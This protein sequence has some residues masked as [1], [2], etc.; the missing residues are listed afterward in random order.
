MKKKLF[1]KFFVFAVIAALVTVTSC[2]DYDD[3]ISRIDADLSALKGTALAQADLT[4]LKT[5]LETSITAVQT[6]LNAAK[7]KLTALEGS[8]AT[9]EDIDAAKADVL[10]KAVKLETFTTFK[11]DVED[12]LATLKADLAKAATKEEV[13]ALE[14]L[15]DA[16]IS[17][18]KL[19][20]AGAIAN[21]EALKEVV[22]GNS[23]AIADIYTKLADQLEAIEANEDEIAA[24]KADLQTKYDELSG[25][26]ATLK[27]NLANLTTALG[28]LDDKVDGIK[29]EL[30]GKINGL[31]SQ[32]SALNGL[33]V[34]VF[35]NLD[36]RVTSL[37]FIPDYSSPD[38][39]PQLPVHFLGEWYKP[40]ATVENWDPNH[41]YD[42]LLTPYKGITY[43][44]F[45]VSPSNATLEDF[46]VVGLLQQTSEVLFR[47]AEEPLLK[48]VVEDVTLKNGILTVPILVHADLYDRDDFTWGSGNGPMPVSTRA[49]PDDDEELLFIPSLYWYGENI[50]VV[51]QVKNKNMDA[52]DNTERLVVSSEYVRTQLSLLFS[53]I[54]LIDEDGDV[55]RWRNILPSHKADDI[56]LDSYYKP[57]TIIELWN[58]YNRNDRTY[59]RDYSINLNDYVQAIAEFNDTWRVLE[60]FGYDNIE[61]HFVF[62][63]IDVQNEGV[64]QSSYVNLNGATGVISVKPGT[65][66]NANQAA[67]G[68]TPVV[69]AKV[70]LDGKVY[71][72]GY[73]K[74]VITEEVDNSPVEFEFTLEDY[75]LG[76]QSQYSLTDIDLTEIDFDQIFDHERIM[77]G[78]DAFFTAY[79]RNPIVTEV[80]SDPAAADG[81][82]ISFDWNI[83]EPT[84]GGSLANYISGTIAN[85]AP[86][87][88][89]VVQ[90]TLTGEGIQP[91]VV[92]TWT[93][94]VKLPE[95]SLTANTA[96]LSDGKIVVNPT[97]LE[98]T[99][100]KTSTAYEA[101]LNNAFMHGTD[102]DFTFTP[103]PEDCDEA[104]T[105]YFVF[106]SAPTGYHI[107]ADGTELRQNGTN[108][109]AAI[110]EIDPADARKYFVRLN[111]DVANYPGESW[112]NYPELSE[113][114]KGLVGKTV[115]VQ[116]RGYINGAEYNWINLYEPFDVEFT[117]P[118]ELVLPADAAVYD[119]ANQ[120]LNVYT[121]NPYD[122]TTAIID[123]NDAEVNILTEYGRS[124]I[125]HYEIGTQPVLEAE[126]ITGWT[127]AGFTTFLTP[128]SYWQGLGAVNRPD[129]PADWWYYPEVQPAST[130]YSSPFTF[131]TA[132]ATCNIQSDGTIGGAINR[133]I[134]AGMQLKYGVVDA[135]GSTTVIV[136]GTT[137]NVPTTYAFEWKNGATGAIAN[138]FKVAVPVS[139]NH[140]WGVLSGTLVIT[141][142]PGSGNE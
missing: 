66:N 83:T 44:K 8:A 119:Q 45:H 100:G 25:E 67:V 13:E 12:E 97:I 76:C 87:G 15:Y 63:L 120:G 118:L 109:L 55:G 132:N 65:N 140:K 60:Q 34:N 90:T 122:P 82:E 128:A 14:T 115:S 54:E 137:V 26:I 92:I 56:A 101:L 23:E 11:E 31:T 19:E 10:A 6:D 46:E 71:A 116:P 48:A 105:P 108:D 133:P 5:Q 107:A 49:T 103:L 47:S 121:F 110:I 43:A 84:E 104:L 127:F 35:N 79:K 27:T 42:A 61:D 62:E 24:V 91:D 40:Q 89:Y 138:E 77:L 53:R 18:L 139:V 111:A 69:L 98:Q 80:I 38:G 96:I 135:A 124:L 9:Q 52:E 17:E 1:F 16:E 78:K 36:K 126:V 86:A 99:G 75:T 73:I 29:E 93:V 136:G 28:D 134:P 57:S 20:L 3:D 129:R 74:I 102:D 72:A 4:A 130:T 30:D 88:T 112:N 22:D 41:N 51:L 33:I 117:Y 7:E 113:A 39:T 123:W 131:D 37:T 64:N 106:T 58:G 32:V 85:T 70:V 21:L 95:Y 2:T 94:T 68:R 59:D 81:S 142:K 114:S 141:V 50:S 125:N